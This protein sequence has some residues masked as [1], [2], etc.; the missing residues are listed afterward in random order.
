MGCAASKSVLSSRDI[1]GENKTE[2][3]ASFSVSSKNISQEA[4]LPSYWEGRTSIH[5][6]KE[7][8]E[9]IKNVSEEL[10]I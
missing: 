5:I 3:R 7:G 9:N 1:E 4:S 2:R 6:S 10:G 8:R